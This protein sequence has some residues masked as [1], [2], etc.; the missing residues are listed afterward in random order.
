M[1]TPGFYKAV[2]SIPSV[3]LACSKYIIIVDEWIIVLS[4][5]GIFGILKLIHSKWNRIDFSRLL[6]I[7]L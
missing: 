4:L 5:G 2:F 3:N 1:Q 7:V 6:F